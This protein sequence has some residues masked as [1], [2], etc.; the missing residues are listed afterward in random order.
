MNNGVFSFFAVLVPLVLFHEFGHFLMC[1]LGGIRVTKFAFGFGKKLFGFT[2][3]GTEYRW[4]L[5]PLGGYVD[6]MGDVVYTEEIPQDVAHFYNK[7][8]WIRFLVLV[9]GPL[10]NLILALGLYWIFFSTQPIPIPKNVGEAYTVGFVIPGSPEAEA[11]LQ[12]GDR[13]SHVLG[14]EVTSYDE[15]EQE[16]IL[17]P[18]KEME[19]TIDRDGTSR[20]LTF[21][22]DR[23]KKYGV[24]VYNFEP[25]RKIFVSEIQPG[26]PA[27][28]AGLKNGDQILK[29]N[30][31]NFSVYSRDHAILSLLQEAAPGPS[32]FKIARDGAILDL[33]IQPELE[34]IEDP[35][36]QE[37]MGVTEVWRTGF[38]P[39]M[40]M[41][42]VHYSFGTGLGI[43]WDRFIG[44]SQLLLKA[45]H[46]L[47]RGSL[48][49]K[50][51][52]GP[53]EIGQVAKQSMDR[54][55][56]AYLLILAV[57]SINLGILNLLPIPVLDGGEIFVL[58]V[59]WITRRDFSIPAKMRI[60]L[61]G[62]FFLVGLMGIVIITDVVKL[63]QN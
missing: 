31:K 32:R 3:K 35:E 8:K 46:Q 29:I 27:E 50:T 16:L 33:E 9:M 18:G 5:I 49:V 36:L 19:M 14:K 30:E 63:F 37:A 52:S 10:F 60:K 1:K 54:G 13:I 56:W 24:G 28:L 6:F 39:E 17:N 4:N 48:S 43:A 47:V 53:I 59:E 42:V 55:L 25:M 12:A 15:V 11:G 23:N 26:K 57:L 34:A 51:L 22:V 7:P 38:R 40:D 45:V 61:V 41:D 58:L 20:T 21:K 44:D 62:F 2:Y